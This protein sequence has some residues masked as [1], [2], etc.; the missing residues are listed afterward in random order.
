M[1]YEKLDLEPFGD[2]PKPRM[3]QNSVGDVSA[4]QYMKQLGDQDIACGLLHMTDPNQP[5]SL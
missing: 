3:L 1:N 5:A 2:K 4:L